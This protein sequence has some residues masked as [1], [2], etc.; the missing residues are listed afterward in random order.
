MTIHMTHVTQEEQALA[1]F[2]RVTEIWEFN[3]FWK[4]GNTF[5]ATLVFAAGARRRERTTPPPGCQER[6][7]FVV[8]KMRTPTES[9]ARAWG[10]EQ[11]GRSYQI[12]VDGPPR[13]LTAVLSIP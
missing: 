1:A 6:A 13:G 2:R 7:F 12:G 11:L 10:P 9:S 5:D 4:R 8:E 3:D